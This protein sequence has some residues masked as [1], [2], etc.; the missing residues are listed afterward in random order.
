MAVIT[1]FTMFLLTAC[2]SYSEDIPAMTVQ[3]ENTGIAVTESIPED[4]SKAT[5]N[6][7]KASDIMQITVGDKQFSITTEQNETFTALKEMLPL[8]LD[9]S[10]LNGNEKY[11]YL[12]TALPSAPEKVGH[13]NEGDIMLYGDSCIVVFYKSFDTSYTYTK[14]GHI[15]DTSGL[16]D[17]LGTGS[18]TVTFEY[19]GGNSDTDSTKQNERY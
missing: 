1:S 12:D 13:I 2:V 6:E 17:V 15:D 11:Y 4:E 14:I 9:M 3:N 16:A 8:T 10:E 19:N 7:E 5:N 18:V